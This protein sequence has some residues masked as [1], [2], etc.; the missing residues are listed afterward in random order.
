MATHI[1]TETDID[2]TPEQ[3]WDALTD[4]GAYASW[5]PFIRRIEGRPAEGARLEVELQPPEGRPMTF[6]PTV[7]SVEPARELRWLGRLGV[8]GIFDGEHSFTLER[9]DGRT[10]LT[11]QERFRGVLVPFVA[12][13]L[14]RTYGPAFEQMNDAL[15]RRVES[16]EPEAAGLAA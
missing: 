2:A 8:P 13:R 12:R 1:V 3:V 6:R 11:H 7:R 5:N 16:R 4:F 10:R 14:R 9:L 15:K